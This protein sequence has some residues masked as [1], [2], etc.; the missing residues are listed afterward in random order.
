MVR[1]RRCSV[2]TCFVVVISANKQQLQPN[3]SDS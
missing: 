2:V 1:D 3:S